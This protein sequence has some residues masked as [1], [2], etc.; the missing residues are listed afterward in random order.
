MKYVLGLPI[1]EVGQ[2]GPDGHETALPKYP[3]KQTSSQPV[4]MSQR[5]QTGDMVRLFEKQEATN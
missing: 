5:C 4:G 3:G 2:N 1:S